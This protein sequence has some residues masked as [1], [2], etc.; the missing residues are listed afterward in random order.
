MRTPFLRRVR[1]RRRDRC[2]DHA[3]HLLVSDCSL[4]DGKGSDLVDLARARGAKFIM[5]SATPTADGEF[6]AF[7]MKPLC[8]DE[9]EQTIARVMS[10]VET[11]SVIA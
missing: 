6:D 3:F 9:L 1:W 4:P 10:T 11:T 5:L 7:L 2:W 8:V